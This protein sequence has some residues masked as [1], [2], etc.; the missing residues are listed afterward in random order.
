MCIL[1]VPGVQLTLE[2]MALIDWPNAWGGNHA[3]HVMQIL[4]FPTAHITKQIKENMKSEASLHTGRNFP[5]VLH[6]KQFFADAVDTLKELQETTL[7]ETKNILPDTFKTPSP[8]SFMKLQPR[9]SSS[10][11]KE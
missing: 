7:V 8:D 2:R 5:T 3:L 1:E 11:S 10:K 9:A 6:A 4:E